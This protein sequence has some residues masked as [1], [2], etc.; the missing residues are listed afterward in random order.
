[1][2]LLEYLSI[3]ALVNLHLGF[4]PSVGKEPTRSEEQWLFLLYWASVLLCIPKSTLIFIRDLILYSV[5]LGD[6]RSTSS[7]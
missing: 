1:M 2:E 4:T 7:Y 3:L 5:I 6:N